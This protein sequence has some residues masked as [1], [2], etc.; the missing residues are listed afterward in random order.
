M[1]QRSEGSLQGL[2]IVCEE[3]RAG[4]CPGEAGEVRCGRRGVGGSRVPAG[5]EYSW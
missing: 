1:T 5:W 4:R 2:A 3:G